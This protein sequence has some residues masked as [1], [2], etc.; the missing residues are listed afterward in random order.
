LIEELHPNYEGVLN[1]DQFI[2]FLEKID[3]KLMEPD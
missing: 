3:P 2:K 1:Y